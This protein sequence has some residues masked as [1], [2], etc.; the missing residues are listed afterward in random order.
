MSLSK[1]NTG[2]AVRTLVHSAKAAFG[3]SRLF[4]E[5]KKAAFARWT[6]YQRVTCNG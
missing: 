5:M 3:M 1:A 6:P 4:R 2:Y